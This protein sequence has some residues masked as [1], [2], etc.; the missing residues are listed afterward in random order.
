MTL[1]ARPAAVLRLPGARAVV[2]AGVVG[3]LSFAMTGLAVLL[4]VRAR[5]G[6]YAT[7]G[8]AS[9]TYGVTLALAAPLRSR[10]ADRGGQTRVLRATGMAT[11]IAVAAFLL[12]VELGAPLAV[13]LG[14]LVV[15]GVVVPPIGSTVRTLWSVL[16]PE[17]ATRNA[18]YALDG[19][20]LELSFVLGPLLVGVLSALLGPAV[21]VAAGGAFG[22]LGALALAATPA[23][24]AWSPADAGARVG[25]LGALGSRGVRWVLVVSALTGAGFGATEVSA[26]AFVEATGGRASAGALLLAVW[27]LGSAVGGLAYSAVGWSGDPARRWVAL[28]GVLAVGAALP[29]LAVGPVSLAVLLWAYGLGIAPSG[30]VASLLLADAALPGTVTEAFGWSTT[31][32]FA[33]ASAGSAIAGP[34]VQAWPRAGL[35][36]LAGTGAA[37][38]LAGLAGRAALHPPALALPA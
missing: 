36:L 4:L 23:S 37:T 19:V 25:L 10:Q 27:S 34:L 28:L 12:A 30:A 26:P 9:A 20:L 33:G 35:A 14:L 15:A 31:A 24:R 13:Q 29:V 7:A 38:L 22:G 1:L 8:L 2:V 32:I 6:S 3:R 21:A 5:T 11:P 16:A 17:T 18:A